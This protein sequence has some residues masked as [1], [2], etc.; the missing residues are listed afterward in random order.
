MFL[1][2]DKEFLKSTEQCKKLKAA[3]ISSSNPLGAARS[4]SNG[5]SNQASGGYN[6]NGNGGK[7]SSL[8]RSSESQRVS[9]S[10]DSRDAFMASFGQG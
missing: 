1:M 8:P 7:A 4:N 10:V 6:R 5:A 3:T 2:T 9:K